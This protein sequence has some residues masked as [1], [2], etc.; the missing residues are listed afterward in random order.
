MKTG[1]LEALHRTRNRAEGGASVLDEL[2]AL[3]RVHLQDARDAANSTLQVLVRDLCNN[4]LEV[5][6]GTDERFTT[7]IGDPLVLSHVG[8]GDSVL[9]IF[10]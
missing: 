9:G 6:L 7:V 1:T 3:L 2:K 4:C 8:Y 10:L 5:L